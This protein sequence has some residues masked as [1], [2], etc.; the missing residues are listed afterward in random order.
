MANVRALQIAFALDVGMLSRTLLLKGITFSY[1]GL[2]KGFLY[3]TL[4]GE[5]SRM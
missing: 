1:T 2:E 4:G 5:S 3:F